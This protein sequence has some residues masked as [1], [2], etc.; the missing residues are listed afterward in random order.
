MREEVDNEDDMSWMG[1]WNVSNNG[2]A[3]PKAIH[4]EPYT[5][6]I[7]MTATAVVVTQTWVSNDT[8]N[9]LQ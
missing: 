4:R 2:S 1:T 7:N 8:V 3:S 9:N 6:E 5:G